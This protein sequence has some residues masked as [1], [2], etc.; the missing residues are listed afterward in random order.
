MGG[1]VVYT[2]ARRAAWHWPRR[3]D[4]RPDGAETMADSPDTQSAGRAAGDPQGGADG[5]PALV[6]VVI[7]TWNRKADVLACVESVLRSTYRTIEVIVVDNASTDGTMEALRGQFG[8]AVRVI[9]SEVNLYAGGGRNLGARHAGG[10]YLLFIDSDNVV[11]ERM[12]EELVAGLRRTEP[13]RI[14]LGGPLFYYWGDRERLCGVRWDINMVTSRTWWEGVGT[15]D[16]GQFSGCDHL[17]VGHLPNVFMLERAL[18][19]RVGGIDPDYVMHYEES[20]LAER[21]KRAGWGVALFPRAKTW[22]KIPYEK[23]GGDRQFAGSN[24][25]LLYYSVRNRILFMR[26]NS[27]GWRLAVFLAVFANVFLL[28]NV[29][30][31]LANGRR[32]L[33]GLVLRAHWAGLRGEGG[34]ARL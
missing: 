2:G 11:D 7:P 3:H 12:I 24:P 1:T 5:G 13:Q 17:R 20:D 26:K 9:R 21:V 15:L 25:G 27:G 29:A 10:H 30:A 18:F 23:P 14:G 32:D 19:E 22:H 31:L 6:S 33:I 8:E 4:G 28:Y 16:R 34:A